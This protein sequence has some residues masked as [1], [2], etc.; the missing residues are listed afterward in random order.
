MGSV[1]FRQGRLFR[2]EKWIDEPR[3]GAGI[4]AGRPHPHPVLGDAQ[5]ALSERYGHR[6]DGYGLALYRDGRT[7]RPSTATGTCGGSTTR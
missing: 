3:L 4:G 6:F 5:Q 7:C 1:S 2:Y